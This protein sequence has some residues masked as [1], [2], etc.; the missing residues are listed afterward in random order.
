MYSP[1]NP[2]DDCKRKEMCNKCSHKALQEN[3][4]RALNKIIELSVELGKPITILKT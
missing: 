3:Y 1:Y 2:C 4:Q